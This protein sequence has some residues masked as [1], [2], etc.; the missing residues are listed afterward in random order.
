MSNYYYV[1]HQNTFYPVALKEDYQAAGTWP[2]N[3]VY[4]T[5]EEHQAL[6]LGLSAGKFVA[7]DQ[8]GCPVL[9]EP[10]IN[11]QE[12]AETARKKL[13]NEANTVTA[14]WRVEL[15]LGAITDEDKASLTAWMVYIRELKALDLTGT[16]DEE[17]YNAIAWPHKPE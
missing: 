6:M 4:I 12:R 9:T 3:G 13:L 7:S 15:M 8:N 16:T 1:T 2:D 17:G 11:W 5:E 10:E 14:D